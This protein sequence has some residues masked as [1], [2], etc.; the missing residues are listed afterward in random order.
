MSKGELI[1]LLMVLSAM[2]TFAAVIGFISVWSR[3]TPKS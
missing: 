3:Q 2:V 1:Y